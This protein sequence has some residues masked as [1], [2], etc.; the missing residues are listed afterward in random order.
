[1]WNTIRFY[2]VNKTV[3][4]SEAEVQCRSGHAD[5]VKL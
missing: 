1:M 2:G 3:P 4:I 5:F